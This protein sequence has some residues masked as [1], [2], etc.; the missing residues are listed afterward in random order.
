MKEMVSHLWEEWHGKGETYPSG[1]ALHKAT[2]N[3]NTPSSVPV[4]AAATKC[5]PQCKKGIS[6]TI[7]TFLITDSTYLDD[8]VD[9]NIDVLVLNFTRVNK[10]VDAS[11]DESWAVKKHWCFWGGANIFWHLFGHVYFE[12][13]YTFLYQF[14]ALFLLFLLRYHICIYPAMKKHFLAVEQFFC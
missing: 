9:I 14:E 1:H 8:E 2:D 13:A 11:G 5:T 10:E 3:C 12:L 6:H 4:K 7:T